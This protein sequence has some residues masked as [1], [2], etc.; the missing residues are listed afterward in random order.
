MYL[1]FELSDKT[2]RLLFSNG[3]K[4]RN[5]SIRAGDLA[6]LEAEIT[7]AR[8][9]LRLPADVTIRSC[10]EAGREGFWLHRWLD[11][12]GVLNEVIDSASIEVDRR[13]RRTKT[14]RVDAEKLMEL[15]SRR[16]RLGEKKGWR[17]CRVP[18]QEEEDLRQGYRERLRL[19][20]EGLALTSHIQSL[21]RSRGVFIKHRQAAWLTL[22]EVVDY[23]GQ[24]L[25]PR[26]VADLQRTQ[27][28]LLQVLTA[29]DKNESEW[30]E[31]LYWGDSQMAQMA[32][33]LMSLKGIGL[34]GAWGLVAEFFG[35]RTF[36]NGKAVGAAAG[37]TGTPYDSGVS[38]R[39][40]GISKAGNP[41]VRSLAVQLA[42]MWVRLQPNSELTKWFKVRF[43]N[44]TKRQRRCGIVAVARK[45]LIALWRWL[46]F[47]EMPAGAEVKQRPTKIRL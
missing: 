37:L 14:D 7:R 24:P 10:Y 3:T 27:E 25:P 35:W 18:S 31:R 1:V 29:L 45:L 13:R 28:R 34:I 32:K 8:E 4:Y 6:A 19:Q 46:E 42:W 22:T 23:A 36:P 12:R 17:V 5:K 21:L 43:A 41:R 11:A 38:M 47:D 9:R 39:E 16:W 44:G 2:W 33:K 15:L 20:K 30:R 26:L 40:Q